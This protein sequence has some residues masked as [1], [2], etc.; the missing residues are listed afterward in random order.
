MW[1]KQPSIWNNSLQSEVNEPTI[2]SKQPKKDV[3]QMQSE[4]TVSNAY[5]MCHV[6]PRSIGVDTWHCK[7]SKKGPATDE[8]I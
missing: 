3:K 2:W 6:V 5:T 4:S 8:A 7:A 1:N